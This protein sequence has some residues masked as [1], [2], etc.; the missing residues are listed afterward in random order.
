MLSFSD[1]YSKLLELG[2]PKAQ[3]PSQSWHMGG[4]AK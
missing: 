1:A 2:V 4:E 3:F